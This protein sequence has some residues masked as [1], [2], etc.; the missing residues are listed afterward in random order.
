M[1]TGINAGSD[2]LWSYYDAMRNWYNSEMIFNDS[3][4]MIR[5]NVLMRFISFNT[6]F[7]HALIM[8]F[9][10][11]IGLTGLYN[12][13]AKALQK[14]E[15][16]LMIGVYLLPSTLLWTSG[17]IKEAFLVFSIGSLIYVIE[18]CF[19]EKINFTK[20][21]G[22]IFFSI[23]LL[24]IKSYILIVI[25]PGILSWLVIKKINFNKFIIT[26]SIHF[27]YFLLLFNVANFYTDQSIPLRLIS[28]QNE[29]ENL[30]V[31][32][33]ANS[34]I[35]LPSIENST[36]SVILNSPKGFFNTLMRPTLLESKNPLL[37]AAG[38][39][40]ALFL[41]CLILAIYYFFNNKNS[42]FSD[43]YFPALFFVVNMFVMIG[44]VTPIIGAIVRYKVPA[45]PF[46]AL[47]LISNIDFSKMNSRLSKLIQR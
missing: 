13:F 14:K 38:L 44:L 6:Y 24:Y 46:L 9:L 35:Q 12:V 34:V 22:I 10:S 36:V 29:F 43:L 5:I 1:L 23:C 7:P 45:L 41:V 19:H 17:M 20:I 4:T 40:N 30:V 39:E 47:L 18:K 3:R 37:L 42:N 28:K 21:G 32:E 16:I 8:T 15:F 2:E 31:T 33:K 26:L 11:F 27:F 25:F